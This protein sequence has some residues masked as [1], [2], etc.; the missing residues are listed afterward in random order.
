MQQLPR[1]DGWKDHYAAALFENDRS[2]IPD[3]IAC[4]EREIIT[5]SRALFGEAEGDA[6]EVRTLN[7]ALRMLQV[8]RSSLKIEAHDPMPCD[9]VGEN[10]TTESG[11]SASRKSRQLSYGVGA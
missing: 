8:L 5:R 3:L 10:W 9:R 6:R 11:V 2:K 7:N 1:H 4:A